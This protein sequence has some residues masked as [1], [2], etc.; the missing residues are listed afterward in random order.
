M[1]SNSYS[2]LAESVLFRFC[3]EVLSVLQPVDLAVAAFCLIPLQ[4]EKM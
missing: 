1:A 4:E 3:I 2:L